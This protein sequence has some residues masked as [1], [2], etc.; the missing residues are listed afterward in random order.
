VNKKTIIYDTAVSLFASQGYE[1]TTTLQVAREVGIT[2]PAVF[3]HFKNKNTLFSIV[4]EKALNIYLNRIEK[5]TLSDRSAFDCLSDLIKV[6]FSIVVEEPE[7]VRIL[8]RACP[9]KL[10]DPDSACTKVYRQV[11]SALRNV[12]RAILE[13]GMTSAEFIV[14]DVIATSNLIIAMINGLMSQQI[15]ALDNLEGVEAA[16]IAFCRNALLKH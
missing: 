16:T 15:A 13:N 10:E 6:H 12:I 11:R 9:A 7:Y 8:L 2:E 5:V 3:Y 1:S 4:L 14:V